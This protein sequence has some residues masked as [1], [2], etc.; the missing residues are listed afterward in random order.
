MKIESVICWTAA[1]VVMAPLVA[2][3]PA[4]ADQRLVCNLGAAACRQ[5]DRRA[6]DGDDTRVRAT[7]NAALERARN[8]RAL[9]DAQRARADRTARQRQGAGA[10]DNGV[11][12]RGE[13]TRAVRTC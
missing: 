6:A 5:L 8:R 10:C 9:V 4:V 2:S 1:L 7:G 11:V 3:R 13:N 12:M